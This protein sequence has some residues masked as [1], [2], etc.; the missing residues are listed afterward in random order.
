S[1]IRVD[2]PRKATR[3]SRGSRR[4][5]LDAK[6]RRGKTKQLRGRIKEAE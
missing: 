2:K 6:T 5:R 1:A 4:R 3:P